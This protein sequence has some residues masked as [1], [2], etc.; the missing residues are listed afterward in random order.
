[1]TTKRVPQ[2]TTLAFA[3]SATRSLALEKTGLITHLDLLLKLNYT[4][5]DIT[6]LEDGIV[7]IIKGMAIRDGQGHTWDAIGDGRQ[8]YWKNYF[9]YQ[10]QVRKDAIADSQTAQDVYALLQIHFGPNPLNPF[11]PV[12]GIPAVELGQ[13]ALEVTWG[14]ATDISAANLVINSGSITVTP[15]IIL[16]G[17]QYDAVR[18]SL[19]LP[20]NRWEKVDVA[21]VIGEIGLRRELPAGAILRKTNLL[22]LAVAGTRSNADVSEVGYI[23]A[24]ENTVPF[25]EGWETLRGRAQAK[26]GLP[27]LPTGVAQIDWGEVAGDVALDLRGR[28]PGLDLIGFTTLLATGDIWILH[29]AYSAS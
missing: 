13:L 17:E 4:S 14:A 16:A 29:T 18:P 8:L 12:S 3:A 23:K 5:T 26:Y 15:A 9:Q 22:V 11:D 21:A 28:L 25:R 2:V 1:M 10:G 27:S 20:N 7:R 19:L 6:E 24:L